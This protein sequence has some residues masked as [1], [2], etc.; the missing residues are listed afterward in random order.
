MELYFGFAKELLKK[1]LA[2]TVETYSDVN[3]YDKTIQ[4]TDDILFYQKLAKQQGGNVLDIGCGTGRIMQ[5]L[6][7]EGISVIGMDLSEDMLEV[8]RKKLESKGH[9][10]ILYHG[11]MRDYHIPEIF[12]LIIIP[13]YSMIYIHN[14]DDRKKVFQSISKHLETGGIL[15]FDFDTGV[16]EEG[17]SRPWLSMQG[18]DQRTGEVSVRIAQMKG[19]NKNL[20][21]VNQINYRY[22]KTS[23]QITVEASKESTCSAYAMKELLESEGFRING[24][25]SDY[26]YTPYKDG[27]E[28][29]VVAEKL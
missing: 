23:T 1:G 21:V 24:F 10:P 3:L 20:R 14:D 16:C 26:N 25:Y 12:S 15:A 22:T 17:E 19:I 2:Q 9:E 13:Y 6:L 28:C 27:E 5:A 29:V 11:D 7:E 18:M 8:A 4:F